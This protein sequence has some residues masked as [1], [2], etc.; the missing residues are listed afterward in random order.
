MKRTKT[1]AD[2]S[3]EIP[4]WN[5][6]ICIYSKK[7]CISFFHLGISSEEIP[8][9]LFYLGKS[10]REIPISLLDSRRVSH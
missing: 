3:E 7:I 9:F 5:R 10:S 1:L 2:S 6:E 4:K 8:I